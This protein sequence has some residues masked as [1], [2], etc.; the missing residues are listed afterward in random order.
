MI[1]IL[2]YQEAS[3][4]L[5]EFDY[6]LYTIDDEDNIVEISKTD[7]LK[8]DKEF[9]S[10][11][12][13]FLTT[14]IGG[15]NFTDNCT[16]KDFAASR[17]ISSLKKSLE[18]S[19]RRLESSEKTLEIENNTSNEYYETIK[20]SFKTMEN[21]IIAKLKNNKPDVYKTLLKRHSD[22]IADEGEDYAM[23]V[24][25]PRI[26]D[27]YN[28]AMMKLNKIIKQGDFITDSLLVDGY[29]IQFSYGD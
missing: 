3:D 14:N 21:V 28:V 26:L 23:Y 25:S 16:D 29:E 19:N 6:P 22:R 18:T 17:I 20:S 2:N 13:S 27:V 11:F 10:K 1:K 7:F 4:Y 12:S 9:S 24:G 8:L 5:I 15:G